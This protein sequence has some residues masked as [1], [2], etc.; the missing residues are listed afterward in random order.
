MIHETTI[1]NQ[2]AT[3]GKNLEAMEY[4]VIGA[5][6][7]KYVRKNLGYKREPPT[8]G[9]TIGNNVT[10]HGGSYIV[11]GLTRNTVIGN[12]VVIGQ[13]CGVGH[14]CIIGRGAH[15]LADVVCV[16]FVEVGERAVI[17]T[18][19]VVKQRVKIGAGS[20]IGMGSIV[21]KDIPSNVVAYNTCVDGKVYCRPMG[22]ARE[23]WKNWIRTNLI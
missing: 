21:T 11:K 8:F 19:T 18:G 4:V 15:L 9:V 12:D 14:D 3:I 20:I 6:P 17:G 23:G 2:P 1:I 13:R 5:N 22:E 10:I 16:G 7:V